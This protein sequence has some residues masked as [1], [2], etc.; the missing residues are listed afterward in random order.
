MR[1]SKLPVKFS[2]SVSH[3]ISLPLSIIV[4]KSFECGVFPNFFKTAKVVPI[5][6]PGDPTMPNNYRPISILHVLSKIFEK[7]I[8]RRLY[9]Y[10]ELKKILSN[11]Q[12]GFRKNKST[13]EAL[14]RFTQYL[15]DELDA[16]KLVL[17][18]FLDFN[19]SNPKDLFTVRFL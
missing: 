5:P 17:F 1:P 7:C 15:Y 19:P 12:F 10:L 18:V 13:I 8:Y 16:G 6:K 14:T 4:N 2:K 3:I 9:D 11:D